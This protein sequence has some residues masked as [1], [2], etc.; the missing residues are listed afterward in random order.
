MHQPPPTTHARRRSPSR[1][2]QDGSPRRTPRRAV[3]ALAGVVALGSL[4]ALVAAIPTSSRVGTAVAGTSR[5]VIAP[6]GS[7]DRLFAGTGSYG[8][9]AASFEVPQHTGDLYVG[10]ALRSS[11]ASTGYRAKVRIRPDGALTTSIV[12]VRN[13]ETELAR[14]T[15]TARMR[16]GES[17]RVE[18]GLVGRSPVRLGLRAWRVGAP[19]PGW[20]Q[21][22]T[23]AAAGR[24]TA[25]G[26]ARAWGYLSASSPARVAVPY[27][28]LAVSTSQA[29]GLGRSATVLDPEP[30]PAPTSVGKRS[31]ANTGV[32]SGT[33]LTRHDGNITV[34]RAGTVLQNLDVHGLVVIKA[35]NVTIRNSILRGGRPRSNQ[36][37][38]TNYGYPNLL[39]TD[40]SFIPQYETVYQDGM[41]GWNY[42]LRRVHITGNV[43]SAKVQGDNVTIEQSLLENTRYYAHDPYQGGGHSHSD[44]IQIQRGR[45][46]TIRGNTV[47]GHSNFAILGAA[48]TGSTPNLKITGNWLDGGHC[49]VKLQ[50]LGGH[51]LVVNASGNKFGPHRAVQSCPLVATRGSTV[52]ASGNTMEY[53]GKPVSVY[54]TTS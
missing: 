34:T 14:R 24:I 3:A 47:R 32:P 45:N 9:A 44:G 6:G 12:R 4:A 22:V 54:W 17:I 36:G 15:S 37:M 26:G 51:S 21:K 27:K 39:V 48:A 23:D 16:P 35:P 41:K 33:R 46:V 20:Q 49:T 29:V 40:T 2:E 19:R 8:S 5:L 52:S 1:G 18:L 10:V 7:A 31:A 42:T 13:G 25:D 38:L 28:A 43:D 11:S 50:E 53:T 30:V